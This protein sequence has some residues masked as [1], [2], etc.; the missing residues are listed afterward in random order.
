MSILGVIVVGV[1]CFVGG[2]L[3]AALMCAN[4]RDDR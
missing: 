1:L 2:F 4:G 3:L